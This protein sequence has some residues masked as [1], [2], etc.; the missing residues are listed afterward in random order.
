MYDPEIDGDIHLQG[1][2][3][4][5][6]PP[7][8]HGG[9][10]ARRADRRRGQQQHDASVHAPAFGGW[11]ATPCEKQTYSPDEGYDLEDFPI[12]HLNCRYALIRVREAIVYKSTLTRKVQ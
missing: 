12:V 7:K 5:D 4:F 2:C 1:A 3:T 11:A 6:D 9:A 10:I 8:L